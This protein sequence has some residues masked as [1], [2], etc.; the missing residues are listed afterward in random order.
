V[1]DV[2]NYASFQLVEEWLKALEISTGFQLPKTV[3]VGN[4]SML[5]KNT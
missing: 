1:Y 4:K 5:I 2:T 3:L